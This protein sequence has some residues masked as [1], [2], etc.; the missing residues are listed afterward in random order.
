M[1]VRMRDD[2]ILSMEPASLVGYTH[3]AIGGP[4]ETI[5]FR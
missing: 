5:G 3:S 1:E 2:D 4:R